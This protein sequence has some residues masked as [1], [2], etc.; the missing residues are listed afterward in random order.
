MALNLPQFIH[1]SFAKIIKDQ[2]R[3]SQGPLHIFALLAFWLRS[4][5][6]FHFFTIQKKSILDILRISAWLGQQ[7][8]ADHRDADPDR[9]NQQSG[10][11]LYQ[12]AQAVNSQGIPDEIRYETPNP[13]GLHSPHHPNLL[14]M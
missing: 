5:F 10:S 12:A 13:P 9:K 3:S 7:K 6:I 8:Q 11:I 4:S 2:G 1:K 14:K